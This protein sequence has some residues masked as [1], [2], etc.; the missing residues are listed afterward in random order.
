MKIFCI[1]VEM[2]TEENK[3]DI[4]N[5]FLETIKSIS[6]IPYQRRAWISGEPPG[7]DFDETVNNYSLDAKGILDHYK[8]FKITENQIHILK[9]FDARFYVFYNKND[10]PPQ[11]IDTPEW[12]K[13]TKDAKEVLKEFNYKK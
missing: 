10:W 12:N 3:K 2:L 13:I 11:F 9:K 8:D 1:E 4:L 6:D 7:T 5:S